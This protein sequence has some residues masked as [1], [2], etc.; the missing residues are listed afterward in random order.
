MLRG[1][2]LSRLLSLSTLFCFFNCIFLARSARESVRKITKS[3]GASFDDGG[4]GGR[5][6]VIDSS[7]GDVSKKVVCRRRGSA[8]LTTTS[9]LDCEADSSRSGVDV[10][11]DG[12]FGVGVLLAE[13]CRELRLIQSTKIFRSNHP[14]SLAFRVDRFVVD[15]QL[16]PIG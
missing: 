6:I 8:R 4:S 12:R 15:V 5:F 2:D 11:E 14:L 16:L 13:T 3:S 10:H 7:T 1:R 9:T